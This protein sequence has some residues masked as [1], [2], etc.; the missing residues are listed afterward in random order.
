MILADQ[1]LPRVTGDLAE[2]VV[3][4]RDPA[5]D[6]GD[7]DDRRVIE[8]PLE[9]GQL[10]R[11]AERH[12]SSPDILQQMA[13]ATLLIVDDEALLRWSL[14]QRLEQEGYDILEADTAAGAIEQA[15]AGVDLILLDFKL[16]D[17]NG[18][19]VLKRVK[20]RSPETLVILMTAFSTIENAVEAMKHGRVPL[21]QQTVQ[22]RR[23]GDARREGARDQPPSPRGP[24]A[25][26]HARPGVWLRRHHRRRRR[27]CSRSS[28]CWRVSPRARP[29]RCS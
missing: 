13:N 20:E 22:P 10:S 3:D 25:A 27:R 6:V 16:P 7:R 18:L 28:R 8:R 23:S 24:R 1:L 26:D 14:K 11:V 12:H 19:S 5:G 17:D 29:R 9:I 4:V 2:L 21:R 15:A